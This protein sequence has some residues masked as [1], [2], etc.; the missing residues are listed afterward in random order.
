MAE[1][2][3]ADVLQEL[4]S[5]IRQMGQDIRAELRSDFEGLKHDFEGLKHDVEG[6]K[7]D[8]AALKIDVEGLKINV[9]DLTKELGA[10]QKWQD[11]TW[12]VIK[13]VGAISAGLSIS[14]SIGIVGILVRAIITGT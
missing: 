12:D 3:L 10:T 4:R 5:D 6:L 8:V 11:R 1:L 7:H 2:T 13:W 9:N 14:A